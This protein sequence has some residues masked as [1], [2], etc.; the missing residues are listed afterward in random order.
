MPGVHK[1][2]YACWRLKAVTAMLSSV[3]GEGPVEQWFK[4]HRDE[5]DKS[6]KDI[7][8]Q[9]TKLEDIQWRLSL[10]ASSAFPGVA[11]VFIITLLAIP[12]KEFDTGAQ[13]ALVLFSALLPLF[14]VSFIFSLA[15]VWQMGVMVIVGI[16]AVFLVG[17]IYAVLDRQSRIASS[18]FLALS[19][20]AMVTAFVALRQFFRN[21]SQKLKELQDKLDEALAR[22]AST[23][24]QNAQDTPTLSDSDPKT[25]E[26]LNKDDQ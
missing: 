7:R 24:S 8:D 5:F 11:L 9:Q 16:G 23:S 2:P 10:G 6:I 21:M 22:L 13:F 14:I 4:E 1:P 18:V 12:K 3:R 15:R 20:A 17:G 25:Q 19:L 26:A